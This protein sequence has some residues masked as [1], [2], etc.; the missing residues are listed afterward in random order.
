MSRRGGLVPMAAALAVMIMALTIGV[1]ASI[2]QL[3]VGYYDE[4]CPEAEGIVRATLAHAQAHEARSLVSVMRLVFH[5]CFVVN[6]EI[7]AALCD[8]Q[9]SPSGGSPAGKSDPKRRRL[10]TSVMLVLT[11]ATHAKRTGAHARGSPW[12]RAGWSAGAQPRRRRLYRVLRRRWSWEI[13]SVF[14]FCKQITDGVGTSLILPRA[15]SHTHSQS[16][17]VGTIS[18]RAVASL[19]HRDDFVFVVNPSGTNGHRGKQWKQ[20]LPHLRTCLADHCNICERIT[21]GPNV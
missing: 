11:V 3:K 18:N 10:R 1:E 15:S 8:D 21:S 14:L 2:K 12:W 5:N 13:V 19:R 7:I 4:L 9:S 20:L 6:K 16:S 17:A